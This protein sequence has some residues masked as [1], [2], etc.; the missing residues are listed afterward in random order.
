MKHGGSWNFDATATDASNITVSWSIQEGST[1]GGI[2]DAGVYTAP[3]SNGIYHVIATSKADS[4]KSATATV[5][6]GNTGFTLTGS[7]TNARFNHT[8]TLL[9]NGEVFIGGGAI[10]SPDVDDGVVNVDQTEL[11]N[12]DTDTFQ[13]GGT[14]TRDGHTATLLKNGDVLFTGGILSDTLNEGLVLTAN[15]VLLTAG[16]GSLQP[17]GSMSIG[18]Y[19][20]TAT[21]LQ[22]GRVLVTGGNV[23]SGT[24]F[25]VTQTAE[26]YDPASGTFTRV[27]DLVLARQ[28]HSA[29]LLSNG[30]VLIIGGGVADAELFDPAT[31]T[32]TATGSTSSPY[33]NTATL[34][35]DGKVL[36]TGQRTAD[37]SA[38]ASA[39]LYDPA[40]GKFT[41]TGTMA[42]PRYGYTA[43][44]L[45]DGTV[46]I[47]GGIVNVASST[48]GGF[49][50]IPVPATEIYNPATGSF[51]PGPTMH[52]GRYRPTATLLRDGSVLFV[53]GEGPCCSSAIGLAPLASAEIYQ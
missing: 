32:F 8:A 44:L 15:S 19:F 6:V 5:S 12:P 52:Q 45:P 29:T 17:T 11:F 42:T 20:H 28:S 26:I 13:S 25:H 31:N 24:D 43:T 14:L 3:A 48:P 7:L 30:K 40:T 16:S 50:A 2:S 9:P 34:L 18:R 47:A 41:P 4:T 46:L 38:P 49:T 33:G 35:A 27:G 21:V 39:E 37:G 10:P 36:V 1:G 23:G 53:G 51:N 22:D